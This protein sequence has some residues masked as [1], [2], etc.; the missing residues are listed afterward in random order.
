MGTHE[1]YEIN[2]PGYLQHDLDAMKKGDEP[3]D[4]MLYK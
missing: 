2:L 1:Y 4:L 3:Y